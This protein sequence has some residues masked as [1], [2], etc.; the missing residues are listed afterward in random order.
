MPAKEPY[1]TAE[2]FLPEK[3]SLPTLAEAA[4]GCKGCDLYRNATQT[5][6]GEGPGKARL[7]LVGEQPGDKEDLAGHPFVG[8]AGQL[9]D[10]ALVEAGIP[11]DEVYV[12]NAVK[13]FSFTPRG[14]RRMHQKPTARQIGACKPWLESEI[15][16]LKPR[17]V[18][19]LGATAA[20]ALLG[21]EFR[22]TKDRGKV[23]EAESGLAVLATVHPSSLLRI[24]DSR[25]R[26]A[27][28][29]SFVADLRVAAKM[30]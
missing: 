27:A 9:L 22:V 30:L 12:T 3:R 6:F 7:I 20:Q 17:L 4:K 15:E 25:E 1:P 24:P 5:V 8:P 16:V 26:E 23:I 13:H 2:P 14:K 10:K 11:R 18:V 29:E 21:A 19:C 28:Y